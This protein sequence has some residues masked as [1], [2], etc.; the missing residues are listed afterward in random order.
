MSSV[1]GRTFFNSTANVVPTAP[2]PIMAIVITLF[3]PF[4]L[5]FIILLL[6]IK[7]IEGEM[8]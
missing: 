3:F 1:S 4:F 6:I 7:E 8:N 5:R 2:E